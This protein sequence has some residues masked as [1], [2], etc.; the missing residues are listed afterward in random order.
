[1]TDG[2]SFYLS[3]HKL[4]KLTYWLRIQISCTKHS[5]YMRHLI[6]FQRLNLLQIRLKFQ[7]IL[8]SIQYILKFDIL[9]PQWNRHLTAL[10]G[11]K[12]KKLSIFGLSVIFYVFKGF[13]LLLTFLTRK[14]FQTSYLHS[15]HCS[16]VKQDKTS[17]K[18][19]MST[20]Q[21]NVHSA[22][23]DTFTETILSNT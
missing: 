9:P 3:G 12:K 2:L 19:K 14:V 4:L 21:N 23:T 13:F 6:Q 16:F 22:F 11:E 1:M 7:R 5:R 18:G 10:K 20:G 15:C 17:L 8:S